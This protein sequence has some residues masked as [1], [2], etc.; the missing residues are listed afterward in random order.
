MMGNYP[1]GAANDPRAPYNEKPDPEIEVTVRSTLIKETVVIGC[2]AYQYVEHEYDPLDGSIYS[3]T[4]T[5]AGDDLEECFRNQDKTPIQIIMD[6]KRIVGEL[7]K[8]KRRSYAD[9]YLP[10]LLDA[11]DGWEEE[12]LTVSD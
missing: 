4:V 6:C 1:P 11:C 12:D 9:I 2:E 5:E 8:K 10:Y 7:L 3:H